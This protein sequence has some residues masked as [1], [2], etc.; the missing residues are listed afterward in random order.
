MYHDQPSLVKW[1]CEN[2]S[3]LDS[4]VRLHTQCGALYDKSMASALDE[5]DSQLV[6]PRYDQLIQVFLNY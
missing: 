5:E 2:P 1:L 4:V 6:L 3:H